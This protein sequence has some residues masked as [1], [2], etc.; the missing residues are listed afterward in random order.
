MIDHP[1]IEGALFGLGTILFTGPVFFTLVNASLQ[2]GFW[3]GISVATGIIVSDILASAICFFGLYQY[4]EEEIS[5]FTLGVLAV[6][7]LTFLAMRFI[8]FPPADMSGKAKKNVKDLF[9]GFSY[10][11]L[12]N[13]VNPFVFAVWLGIIAYA[14]NKYPDN[15]GSFVV[16]MLSTVFILDI[17]RAY[18]AGYLR[19]WLKPK[20]LKIIFRL[21]GVILIAF[22]IRI[23]YFLT[24]L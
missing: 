15:A 1:I 4:F 9:S 14:S 20:T 13:F 16:A 3:G 8:L 19:K 18:F 10:G 23:I 7:I 6:G 17:L 12:V 21:F 11:F 22:V 5:E 2:H 24:Q